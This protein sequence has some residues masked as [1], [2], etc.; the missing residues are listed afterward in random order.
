VRG[1]L[2]IVLDVSEIPAVWQRLTLEA[3]APVL[4]VSR[5]LLVVLPTKASAPAASD[6]NVNDDQSQEANEEHR[7]GGMCL[8]DLMR[9]NQ[10]LLGD[11]IEE[12]REPE[13]DDAG[14]PR[15]GTKRLLCQLSDA[16][17]L[18]EGDGSTL[19]ARCFDRSAP[20]SLADFAHQLQLPPLI[21]LCQ[22]VAFHGRGK[23]ALRAQPQPVE[24]HEARRL[25]DSLNE[26]LR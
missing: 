1:G 21:V 5:P 8:L 15:T 2:V 24:R 9:L 20:D 11:E 18:R 25:L 16:G 13:G 19:T 26:F 12:R 3:S 7:R 4:A 22:Q 6:H 10:Q 17:V 23:P 14:K